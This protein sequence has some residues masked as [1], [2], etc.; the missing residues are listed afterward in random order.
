M[1][2]STMGYTDTLDIGTYSGPYPRSFT[3]NLQVP[4]QIPGGVAA[5][6]TITGSSSS[7]QFSQT[8]DL[9]VKGEGGPL[10]GIISAITSAINSLLKALGMG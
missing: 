4:P 10:E 7:H 2:V 3:Y 1:T 8:L 6:V 5:K 9:N